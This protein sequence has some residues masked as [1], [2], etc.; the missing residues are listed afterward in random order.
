MARKGKT[1][2]GRNRGAFPINEAI[3]AGIVRVE[4]P[5][6]LTA[7]EVKAA[8]TD[9][10]GLDAEEAQIAEGIASTTL[11]NEHIESIERPGQCAKCGVPVKTVARIQAC[12]P[13]V[14]D[15]LADDARQSEKRFTDDEW[16]DITTPEERDAP[17]CA[18]LTPNQ[19]AKIL[20][21]EVEAVKMTERA[22]DDG[23]SH[24]PP[25][26]LF[27]LLEPL[28]AMR[29]SILAREAGGNESDYVLKLIRRQWVARGKGA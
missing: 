11:C 15:E 22:A 10:L 19:L 27:V 23:P 1:D 25:Q 26:G 28:W 8:Y 16:A 5:R 13:S 17:L 9:R 4:G 18:V 3:D 29:L 2:Q 6:Q 12:S 20:G 7:E 24:E 14:L 21:D